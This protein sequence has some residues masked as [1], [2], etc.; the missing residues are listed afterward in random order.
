MPENKTVG[1]LHRL[2][3]GAMKITARR[4]SYQLPRAVLLW[5]AVSATALSAAC[6]RPQHLP[7]GDRDLNVLVITLDTIRADRLGAYGN[8]RI[9]TAF[10][11]G[12]AERGV[13][14]EHCVAPHVRERRS[15]STRRTRSSTTWRPIP[16]RRPTSPRAG[17]PLQAAS[18]GR[19][20]RC[21]RLPPTVHGSSSV[22]S[23]SPTY[24]RSVFAPH[25]I[26]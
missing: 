11:D 15:T 17:R 13:L 4:P 24:P 5:I 7:G 9:R 8:P 22:T 12:L 18:Q 26:A 23:R 16:V 19:S 1:R 2:S 21:W 25:T 20:N 6:S 3:L 10:V 14:F